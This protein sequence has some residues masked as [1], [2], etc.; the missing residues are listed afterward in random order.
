MADNSK[1]S[2]KKPI[3]SY[4]AMSLQEEHQMLTTSRSTSSGSR[5]HDPAPAPSLAVVNAQPV[6]Y[7]Q[8]FPGQQG[9]PVDVDQPPALIP[10]SVLRELVNRPMP[11]KFSRRM[12]G[13]A[14]GDIPPAI[15]KS[16]AGPRSPKPLERMNLV[17]EENVQS[18]SD[19]E[20]YVPPESVKASSFLPDLTPEE[21]ESIA[22]VAGTPAAAEELSSFNSS[23][24]DA[25]LAIYASKQRTKGN[26]SHQEDAFVDKNIDAATDVIGDA[27]STG[28]SP[29]SSF[30]ETDAAEVLTSMPTEQSPPSED[31]DH[32][33]DEY[34]E[35]VPDKNDVNIASIE[36][37]PPSS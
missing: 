19:D 31:L 12:R 13:I 14:P 3:L 23:D 9:N 11:T 2:G 17:D 30:E 16:Q 36:L 26:K 20:D 25:S 34:T 6:P 37:T 7:A 1:S 32:I 18:D 21:L 35:P 8:I 4:K 22:A 10:T 5:A 27:T 28:D 29:A 33:I 24:W 15:P